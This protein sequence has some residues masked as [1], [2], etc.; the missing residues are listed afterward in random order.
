MGGAQNAELGHRRLHMGNGAGIQQ[1]LHHG[2]CGGVHAVHVQQRTIAVPRAGQMISLLHRQI[3]PFEWPRRRTLAA[4]G[5]LCLQGHCPRLGIEAVCDGVYP[6]FH[7]LGP[8][9][10]RL[11]QFHRR[12]RPRREPRQRLGARE[13]GYVQLIHDIPQAPAHKRPPQFWQFPL[14]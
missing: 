2:R 8:R 6:Q 13:I 7:P 3:Q 14:A 12:Q 9:D 4:P 1:A 5:R 11:Q 10:H